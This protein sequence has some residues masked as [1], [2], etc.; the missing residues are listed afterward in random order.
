MGSWYSSD[1]MRGL[2]YNG[3]VERCCLNFVYDHMCNFGQGNKEASRDEIYLQLMKHR[4]CPGTFF[5][6]LPP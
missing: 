6:C 4:L 3:P 2:I 1:S 5:E